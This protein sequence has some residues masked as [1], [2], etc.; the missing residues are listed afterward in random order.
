MP[1]H[2]HIMSGRDIEAEIEKNLAFRLVIKIDLL[3][4]NSRVS[5][6][7]LNRFRPVLDLLIFC[8][9]AEHFFHIRERVLDLAIYKPEKMQRHIQLQHEGIDQHKVA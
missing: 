2:C 7:E 6:N 8:Q 4:A 5:H 3:E 1:Y 9:E